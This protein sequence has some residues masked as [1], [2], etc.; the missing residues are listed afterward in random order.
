MQN[1]QTINKQQKT[2]LIPKNNSQASIKIKNQNF[3]CTN[4]L[5][6]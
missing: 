5:F 4:N 1:K 3:H 6:Y 2:L